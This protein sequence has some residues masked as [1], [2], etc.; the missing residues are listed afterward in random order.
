MPCQEMRRWLK[1]L[2]EQHGWPWETLARTLGIGE[3]K[4]AA[5]KVRGNSRILPGEQ[6]RMS[7]QLRRIASGE[8]KLSEPN[9]FGRRDAVIA[10]NPQPIGNPSLTMAYDLKIKASAQPQRT[11]R[12]RPT[13]RAF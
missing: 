10:D 6:C 9:K 3:G 13:E 11:S 2:R 12:F 8:L 5:S 4:H 7:R 1:L